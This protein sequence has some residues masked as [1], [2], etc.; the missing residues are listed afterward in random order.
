M[1][2][3]RK[4]TWENALETAYQLAVQELKNLVPE[5]IALRSGC[6]F[7]G[8]YFEVPFL[9]ILHHVTFPEGV[10]FEG[11]R[12]PSRLR[13]VLILHYLIQAKGT[14]PEG[15]WVDFRKLPGGEVYYPVF[16]GRI[17]YPMLKLFAG[18]PQSLMEA[19]GAMGGRPLGFGD[20]SVAFRAFPRVEVAFGIWSGSEEFGPEGFVLFDPIVTDYLSTEDAI[21]LCHEILARLKGIKDGRIRGI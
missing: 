1:K 5:D 14:E 9:G 8:G 19:S 20:V 13:Q 12:Q 17:I 18:R 10:V 16:K 3:G 6:P 7:K 4:S 2:G 15:R 21:W 11:E